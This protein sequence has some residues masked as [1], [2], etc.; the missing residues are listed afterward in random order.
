MLF[1]L[2]DTRKGGV[3]IVLK[4]PGARCQVP[5]ARC[6]VPGARCHAVTNCSFTAAASF[7]TFHLR[8]YFLVYSW[9]TFSTLHTTCYSSSLY[10]A[11]HP[12]TSIH[13]FLPFLLQFLSVPLLVINL[14][15]KRQCCRSLANLFQNLLFFAFVCLLR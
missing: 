13:L 4:V 1:V 5:G 9:H 8:L 15:P 6:Q 7:Q 2:L 12:L 11:A 10:I 3:H 14:L